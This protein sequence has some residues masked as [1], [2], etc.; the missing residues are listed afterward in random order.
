[1]VYWIRR[2]RNYKKWAIA[3]VVIIF[4]LIAVSNNQNIRNTVLNQNN[5][6]FPEKKLVGEWEL[7]TQEFQGTYTFNA[8]RTVELNSP[9][10]GDKYST[11]RAS[12]DRIFL[13][14]GVIIPYRFYN[15][16]TLILT[17][18]GMELSFHKSWI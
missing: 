6:P 10:W 8:D 15:D 18:D 5:L 3:F 9:V 13:A 2:K 16:N 11:W 17:L 4:L 7:K 1:M 14:N 12:G